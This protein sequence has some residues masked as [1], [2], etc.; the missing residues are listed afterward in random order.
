MV[1]RAEET[2][3]VSLKME[4]IL[5]EQLIEQFILL[6]LKKYVALENQMKIFCLCRKTGC[7]PVHRI[8]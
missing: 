8:K 3:Y 7:L 4:S 1:G 5:K 6:G 2:M